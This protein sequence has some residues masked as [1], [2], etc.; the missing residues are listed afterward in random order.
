MSID[1]GGS[2]LDRV[3]AM[4]VEGYSEQEDSPGLSHDDNRFYGLQALSNLD[5]AVN[6]NK[7]NNLYRNQ[8]QSDYS[9]PVKK[10]NITPP[11]PPRKAPSASPPS[12]R[13]GYLSHDELDFKSR[14][15]E[16]FETLDKEMESDGRVGGG[17]HHGPY[18]YTDK[19]PNLNHL[20]NSPTRL[21]NSRQSPGRNGGG[22][23]TDSE[24]LSSPTQVLYATISADKH[25]HP[26]IKT[27]Y[28]HR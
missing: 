4:R 21:L 12:I 14:R 1:R 26:G 16:M 15:S 8:Q 22:N 18:S 2:S 11:K 23:H 28:I 25:K 20:R 13:R 17:P 3:K 5:N 27:D 7:L 24:I 9:V 19:N 6:G 10:N